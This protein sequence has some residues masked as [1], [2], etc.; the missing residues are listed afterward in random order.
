MSLS[1][2]ETS[3]FHSCLCLILPLL[4]ALGN[5]PPQSSPRIPKSA[6]TLTSPDIDINHSQPIAATIYTTPNEFIH[7]PFSQHVPCIA[8]N[9]TQ[10]N[11]INHQLLLSSSAVTANLEAIVACKSSSC[12]FRFKA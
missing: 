9:L 2:P 12:L 8:A 10:P 11:A 3:S 1:S 4:L 6:N 5:L 7:L